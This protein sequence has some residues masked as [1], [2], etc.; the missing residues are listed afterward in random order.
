[1]V[2][3][4]DITIHH[5]YFSPLKHHLYDCFKRFFPACLSQ[6][7]EII[8]QKDPTSGGEKSGSSKEIL[9]T[10]AV[11]LLAFFILFYVG[12]EVTIGGTVLPVAVVITTSFHTSTM[13]A[14]DGFLSVFTIRVD[15][16]VHH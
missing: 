4:S 16:D 5:L 15:R 7:G 9:T 10:P 13:Q 8:P 2:C 11:H 1:M 12:V 6:A 3:K 14:D